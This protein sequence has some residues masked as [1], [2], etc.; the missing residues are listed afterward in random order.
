MANSAP[1]QDPKALLQRVAQ[2]YSAMKSYQDNGRVALVNGD[3][4]SFQIDFATLYK[5][6]S[7]F[8]FEFSRPHPYAPLRHV[9]SKYV[10]GFDGSVA[11]SQNERYQEAPRLE[12][13]S[14]LQTAIAGA[15]GISS[16]SAHSISCLL[17]PEVSGF[18]IL[19]LVDVRMDE[20]TQID[21]IPCYR[22]LGNSPRGGAWD[23]TIETDSL[24]IRR[25]RTKFG[26]YP[27][28]E[29]REN[30]LVDRPLD[31]RL[32]ATSPS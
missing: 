5:S 13:R 21:G 12:T 6:P 19:D 9:V 27:N 22:V 14:D 25:I 30:I 26:E 29:Y 7:L 2:A 28:E 10:V 32:F 31:H 18:S 3:D 23:Y 11:Y 24:L 8:R 17:L 16:G 1:E 20:A 4:P 15:T